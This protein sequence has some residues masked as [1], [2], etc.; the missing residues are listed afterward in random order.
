[1]NILGFLRAYQQHAKHALA[2]HQRH[3]HRSAQR[4][5]AGQAELGTVHAAQ[6]RRLQRHALLAVQRRLQRILHGRGQSGV[7]HIH[8]RHR[9]GVALGSHHHLAHGDV[10]VGQ[11]KHR[12]GRHLG[13]HQFEQ[14]ARA[15]RDV[16]RS[17]QDAAGVRQEFRPAIVLLCHA[18]RRFGRHERHALIGLAS[19]AALHLV[20]VDKHLDLAAQDIGHDRREDVVHGAQL[21]ALGGLHLIG[22]GRDEDDRRVRGT[23]V[24]PDQCGGLETV[25]VGHVDVEQDHGEFAVQHLAQGLAAGI[26]EHEVLPQV[27]EHRAEDQQLLGQ[28]VDDEDVGLL[29]PTIQVVGSGR[30]SRGA[31]TRQRHSQLLRTTSMRAVSTGLDM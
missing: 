20:Q 28:V 30:R 1:M 7:R 4:E 11:L 19:H 16:E 21:V 27:F 18:P 26:D 23:L 12:D 10:V 13:H 14:Q 3:G 24:L 9:F 5:R 15:D 2:D 31:C 25:D 17:A 22:I 29:V 6:G 8:H